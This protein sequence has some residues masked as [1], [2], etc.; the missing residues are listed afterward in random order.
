MELEF[1]PEMVNILS[2]SLSKAQNDVLVSSNIKK[3]GLNK[4]LV[5]NLNS[6]LIENDQNMYLDIPLKFNGNDYQISNV[7]LKDIT[8]V[9]ANGNIV[10]SVA[11][12]ESAEIK[13]IPDPIAIL[14][15]IK[16]EKFFEKNN[17]KKIPIPK[18]K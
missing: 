13:A 9:G 2:T 1:D 6:G 17:V 8:I 16:S 4:I 5:A 3:D 15:E 18:P 7:T 10:R 12:T 14:I 11:R